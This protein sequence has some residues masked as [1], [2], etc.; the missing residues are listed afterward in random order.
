MTQVSHVVLLSC[1]ELFDGASSSDVVSA[2][3]GRK[4]LGAHRKG[5]QMWLMLEGGKPNL[6]MHFGEHYTI[7][8]HWP[9]LTNWLALQQHSMLCLHNCEH[10]M[11]HA[12][13]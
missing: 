5:K 1:A 3:R 8:C 9:W 2:L 12:A 7:R 11:R 4:L 10:F 13:T 6:L